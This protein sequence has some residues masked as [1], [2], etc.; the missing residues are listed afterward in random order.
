MAQ[1]YSEVAALSQLRVPLDQPVPAREGSAG[2]SPAAPP[3]LLLLQLAA[4][5]GLPGNTDLQ[6]HLGLLWPRCSPGSDLP[7]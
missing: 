7:N 6:E 2:G 4:V 5:V 3:A 1:Q